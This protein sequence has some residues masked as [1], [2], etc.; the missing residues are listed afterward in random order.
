MSSPHDTSLLVRRGSSIRHDDGF[1]HIMFV[2]IGRHGWARMITLEPASYPAFVE[3]QRFIYQQTIRPIV[4]M[5]M[6]IEAVM[7]LVKISEK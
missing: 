1:S 5:M 4:M 6:M 7:V 2:R 3:A